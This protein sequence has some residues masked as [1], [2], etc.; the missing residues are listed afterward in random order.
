[1]PAPAAVPAR[2][3]QEPTESF[4]FGAPSSEMSLGGHADRGLTLAALYDMGLLGRLRLGVR[5]RLMVD[6]TVSLAWLHENPRLMASQSHLVVAPNAVLIGLDGVARIDVRAAKKG[7]T[8]FQAID[9]AYAAPELLGGSGAGDH[10]ASIFSL[11]VL[12]WEALAGR[13]LSEV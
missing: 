10:R 6:L 1:M 8:T 13:R 7:S 11:G 4:D 12:T 5:A 9:P 3:H 2:G